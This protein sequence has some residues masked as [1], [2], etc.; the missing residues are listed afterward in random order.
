MVRHAGIAD[1][2]NMLVVYGHSKPKE[3]FPK[4]KEA[5]LKALEIDETLAE[6]HSSLAFIKF[7][8]DWDPSH[9]NANFKPPSN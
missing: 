9:L 8:W 4:A 2:Y 5:A 7:R 3:G 1:C 6:A